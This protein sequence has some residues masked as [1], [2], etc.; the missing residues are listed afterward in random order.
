MVERPEKR[1]TRRFSLRLPV[2]VKDP[3]KGSISA[4]T[5]DVSWRG[6]C[7]FIEAPLPVGSEMQF[8]LTLPPEITLTEA[9][10]LR[11]FARVLRVDDSPDGT[12]KTVAAAIDHYEFLDA[13]E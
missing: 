12:S 13:D 9:I 5:R 6:I 2:T 1:A 11:C 10:R 4:F 8:L 7:F 3:N